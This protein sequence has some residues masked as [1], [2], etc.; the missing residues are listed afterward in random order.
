MAKKKTGEVKI[1]GEIYAYGDNSAASFTQRFNEAR[2]NADEMNVYIHTYGGH[3]FEGSLIYNHIKACDIPVN[4]YIVGVCCSMGTVV[5]LAGSKV[6]MCENSYLMVHAP[7]GG[8]YGN[9][10][11]IEKAAKCLRGIE[12]NFKKIYATKTG[13]SEKE[14]EELFVG[15]NWF[16]AQEAMEAKL[17]DGIVDSIATD[18]TPLPAEEL[19]AQTP[20]ALYQRFSA[21]LNSDSINNNKNKLEMDKEG[22][23]KKFGLTTVTA[24]STDEEV[25][26]AVQAKL[27][28]EKQR[29]DNAEQ[30]VKD[31]A[32]KRIADTVEAA[33]NDKKITAKQKETYVAIGTTSGYD[34]LVTVLADMKPA[35]SL[36]GATR[37]GGSV[38]ASAGRETWTWADWQTKDARGLEAMEKDEP[39]KFEALYKAEF[40]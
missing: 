25:L 11:E 33:I 30:A 28:A 13:K 23:I 4:I 15:D 17:I 8:C 27:D 2:K 9:A 16:T 36:V 1:Y 40:K 20:A 5:M 31:A 34:A 12:K 26:N 39:E 29:A 10:L 24:Q 14:V 38:A 35:P 19:K 22:L 7:S 37:S 21:C 3:V 6:Y 18:V 32:G